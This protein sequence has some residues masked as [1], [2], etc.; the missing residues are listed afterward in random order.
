M[1]SLE[2]VSG[3]SL[4]LA[5][6]PEGAIASVIKVMGGRMASKHLE[7]MGF[8]PMARVK[9]LKSSPPGAMLVIVNESRVALGRGMAM[10]RLVGRVVEL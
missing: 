6:I 9:V 8:S 10:K 5:F 3:G 2:S 4:P 1:M 7:D